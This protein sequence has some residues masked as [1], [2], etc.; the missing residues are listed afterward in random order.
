V[1]QVTLGTQLWT[2]DG[3]TRLDWDYHRSFI[4][5]DVGPG[6]SLTLDLV[7]PVPNRPDTLLKLDMVSENVRWFGSAGAT[8]NPAAVPRRAAG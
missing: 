8:I 6:E 7:M 2:A 1:G 3:G 4:P 5:A